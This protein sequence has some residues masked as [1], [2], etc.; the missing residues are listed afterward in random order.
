[1][2]EADQRFDTRD[3]LGPHGVTL[4]F[5]SDAPSEPHGYRLHTAYRLF[6]ASPESNNL[7]RLLADLVQVAA[8]NIARAVA[9]RH[10]WHP[11]GPD[12]SMV[13]GGDTNLPPGAAY[14][15]VGV[16]TLDSEVGS[17]YQVA[18][19]LREP[20]A[21]GRY[22]SAWDL[23]GQCYVLLT[24]GTALHIDRNPHARL[25]DEGI[26]STKT[27]DA[28]RP[29]HWHNPHADLCERGDYTIR[30]VW[31]QLAALHDTLTTYLC[32]GGQLA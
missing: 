9:S 4:F 6:L 20:A 23:R 26:R 15:G 16:S 21:T 17:W 29:A 12:G 30:E 32:G 24:D 13:N 2:I 25:G 27:L 5:T 1:M 3:A 10:R 31:R 19:S 22:R 8:S 7:P 18:R 14:V 28:D 11:L